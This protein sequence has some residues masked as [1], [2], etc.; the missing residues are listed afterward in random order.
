MLEARTVLDPTFD[1]GEIDKRLSGSFVEHLG[2]CVYGG[3]YEPTHPLADADGFRRDVLELVQELRVPIVRYPGGNFVS[4]YDWEDGVGPASSRPARLETNWHSIEPNRF[5]LGEFVKWCAAAGTEAMLAVN[6]GTRGVA[7]ACALLEYANFPGGTKWSDLRIAHGAPQPFDVRVWCL[8]NEMDGPWQIGHKTA[9]E[10]GR[11]ASETA[12]AMRRVD[13][14]LELIAC[15]SSNASMPTYPDW[16]ATVLDHCYDDVDFLSLHS[17]YT[18]NP[19]D[20]GSF[21]ASALDMDAFVDSVIATCDYVRARKRSKKALNLAFDEWNVWYP[22]RRWTEQPDTW[23]LAPALF[24]DTYDIADAV[25]V[26]SLLNSLLRH[27]SRVKIACFAQ[28]VNVIAPIRTHDQGAAWR[29]TTFYPLRD[30]ARFASG[31][32][33]LVGLDSPSYETDRFGLVPVLDISA[34]LDDAT[35]SLAL[36]VANRSLVDDVRLAVDLR[37]LPGY[38][39]LE[40]TTLSGESSYTPG[41]AVNTEQEPERIRPRPVPVTA[42]IDSEAA[43]VLPPL[44][45]NVVRLAREPA[46]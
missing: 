6:L 3:I 10:Y 41:Q 8:G 45:W 2:R 32:S 17:Y 21:L 1:V 24:E 7:E 43:V 25:V 16:E 39:V 28:L 36:F 38:S 22:T 37:A 26:G 31:R 23:R 42:R 34:A 27:A 33:L 12:K 20:V 18:P 40:H 9:V 14:D 4:S 46:A 30:V 44:S 5:G 29:E 15:G 13:P 35:G 19:H 11:L